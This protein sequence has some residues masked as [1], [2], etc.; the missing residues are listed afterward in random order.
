[1]HDIALT[2]PVTFPKACIACGAPA[3]KLRRLRA[4]EGFNVIIAHFQR[5]LSLSIPL[6]RHCAN[7]RLLASWLIGP[8]AVLLGLGL[9]IAATAAAV[10]DRLDA[11]PQMFLIF[12]GLIWLGLFA[13][14]GEQWLDYWF[15]GVRGKK[16]TED[17][18]TITLRFR[19]D[20]RARSLSNALASGRPSPEH[21]VRETFSISI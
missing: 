17:G 21:E 14:R 4:V 1:M 8:A 13:S 20:E 9:P 6:C 19:E 12:A 16:F 5:W 11:G 18:K 2:T 7:R 3:E 15:L 10:A